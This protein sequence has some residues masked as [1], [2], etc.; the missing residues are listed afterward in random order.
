MIGI[1]LGFV[2]GAGIATGL[3]IVGVALL[4][5]KA[6][7]I[8]INKTDKIIQQAPEMQPQ[9]STTDETQ[10][11][12]LNEYLD[13]Q[14]EQRVGMDNVIQAANEVMGIKTIAQEDK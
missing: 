1:I 6:L 11:K 12:A 3:I 7:N 14:R 10:E 9:T 2:A 4:K 8:H 5:G 13:K